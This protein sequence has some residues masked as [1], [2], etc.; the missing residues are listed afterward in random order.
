MY[1][2]VYQLRRL[3]CPVKIKAYIAL[4]CKL[5]RHITSEP[6]LCPSAIFRDFMY[7]LFLM[8]LQHT[9]THTRINEII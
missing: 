5:T 3:N 6:D 8:E 4:S 2:N 1:Y 9:H 7:H